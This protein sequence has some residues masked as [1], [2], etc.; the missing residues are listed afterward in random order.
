[1]MPAEVARRVGPLDAQFSPVQF[2]DI[3]YCYRIREAGRSCRYVP[4]VEMYH[5]ENVTTG[6]TGSLNYPYL[7]V[8]N[9][10]KFKKKWAHRYTKEDGPPD[11]EWHWAEVKQVRLEDVLV[12]LETLA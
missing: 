7:T 8:K 6:R 12:E 4:D 10:L 1:M 5:F 2:E 3:D 9:G 11:D